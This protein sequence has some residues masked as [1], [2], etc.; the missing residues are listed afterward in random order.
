[1]KYEYKLQPVSVG[2]DGDRPDE[3]LLQDEGILN[4]LGQEGWELVSVVVSPVQYIALGKSFLYFLRR[5]MT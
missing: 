3:G 5:P 1:M 2:D 4:Q